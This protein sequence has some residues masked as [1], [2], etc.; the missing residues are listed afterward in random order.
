MEEP[1]GKKEAKIGTRS[2]GRMD[3]MLGTEG[4]LK[5]HPKLV[6]T[7]SRTLTGAGASTLTPPAP[8]GQRRTHS[9]LHR[10]F[11]ASKYYRVQLP[12][13]TRFKNND[14]FKN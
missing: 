9:L 5:A 3:V 1:E 11:W 7:P 8:P 4:L 12:S 14:P 13:S 6:P 10:G 2:P